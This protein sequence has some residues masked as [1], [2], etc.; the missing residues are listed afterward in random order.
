MCYLTQHLWV[1][2]GDGFG[3]HRMSHCCNGSRYLKKRS[4][5]V[6]YL[7]L[8]TGKSDL[9]DCHYL[10]VGC[11][12][13]AKTNTKLF[14]VYRALAQRFCLRQPVQPHQ[15]EWKSSVPITA[16]LGRSCLHHSWPSSY[17]AEA[18]LGVAGGGWGP[19]P[20]SACNKKTEGRLLCP[21][22]MMLPEH[23]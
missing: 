9:I 10:I 21:R 23:F 18:F 15:R 1:F 8:E 4:P 12:W 22:S 5:F 6:Y 17:T 2:A 3:K 7:E 16:A 19:P 13:R 20:S 14:C 11:R